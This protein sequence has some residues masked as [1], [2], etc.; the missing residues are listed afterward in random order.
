MPDS[1]SN[2][3]EKA[4]MPPGSLVH[5]GNTLEEESRIS[6]IDYNKEK[7]REQQVQSID[8]ALEFIKKTR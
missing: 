6:V 7:I 1:L 2:I 8:Q 5:V 4:G 3:S